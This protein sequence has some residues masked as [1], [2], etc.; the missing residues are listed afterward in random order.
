MTRQMSMLAILLESAKKINTNINI[1]VRV[2]VGHNTY[3]LITYYNTKLK[4]VWESNS[5]PSELIS[6]NFPFLHHY[7]CS[8][9]LRKLGE[10]KQSKHMK[11]SSP[12]IFLSFTGYWVMPH[13]TL[14][15]N[16]DH[17]DYGMESLLLL[18]V[19]T[20][21]RTTSLKACP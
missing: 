13:R 5:S 2:A 21:K 14:F 11:L 1:G 17:E 4:Y 12:S 18:N 15:M 10:E 19:A 6:T 8:W 7:Q 9:D 20:P 3:T 16:Y